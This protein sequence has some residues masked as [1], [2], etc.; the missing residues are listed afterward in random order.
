MPLLLKLLSA[1]PVILELLGAAAIT[2]GVA[3]IYVPAA[4]MVGGAFLIG[5]A[6]LLDEIPISLPGREQPAAVE[7]DDE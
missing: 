6:V 5:I 3:L 2:A 1:L 4:C 7:G